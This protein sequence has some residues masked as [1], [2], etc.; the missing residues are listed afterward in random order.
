MT[1]IP[2]NILALNRARRAQAAIDRRKDPQVVRARARKQMD[3]AK[4]ARILAARAAKT[5]VPQIARDEG[6]S[7]A[8]IYTLLR[9]M[10]TQG[11]QAP[12]S[13]GA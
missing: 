10:Q 5:P 4:R 11:Y 2:A 3:H 12:V 13:H 6:V 9:E 8:R 7:V 1:T